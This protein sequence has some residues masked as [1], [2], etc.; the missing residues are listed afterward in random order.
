MMSGTT[1][2]RSGWLATVG[3]LSTLTAASDIAAQAS[4]HLE[5]DERARTLTMHAGPVSLPADLGYDASFVPLAVS[6]TWGIDGWLRAFEVDLVDG[7][8]EVIEAQLLHHAGLI[9]PRER[10]LF[11]PVARRIAAFGME[12]EGIRLPGQLGYRVEPDDS[13]VL[14]GAFF[15]PAATPF[16]QVYL[17]VRIVYADARHDAR[18]RSVLP[19]YLDAA[20]TGVVR[21]DA[22]PGV[23]E[24]SEVWR[25]AIGGRVLG[26]GGHLHDG[27][28]SV[29]L[30]EAGTGEVLWTGLAE[31]DANGE[32]RGV[33][34]KI[35]H[36]G[37]RMDPERAYRVTATYDNDTGAPIHGAMGHVAGLFLPDDVE[38]MP[39]AD[40]TLP[41]YQADLYTKIGNTG[42]HSH[43]AHSGHAG[44]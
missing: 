31:Y 23:S 19:F 11:N 9:D 36:R 8:G 27:G 18:H 12:A 29:R 25:P 2:L 6:G 44:H 37:F 10:D 24:H 34:R 22:P 40:R 20:P 33:S 41:A 32:L 14:A 39:P 1:R 17:R 4:L 3:V 35:F 13:V 43:T 21:F 15:N 38:A 5:R 26:L 28:V 30:E 16:E 7:E 42:A